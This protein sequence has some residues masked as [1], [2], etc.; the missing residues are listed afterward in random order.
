MKEVADGIP[1]EDTE[2]MTIPEELPLL[3]LR[4]MVLFPDMI[5][6]L[7]VDDERDIALVDAALLRNRMLALI[8]QSD[9][10]ASPPEKE[11][12]HDKGCAAVIL[13]MLKFPDDTT[14]LL[15][16]GISRLAVR[17]FTQEEPFFVGK[18][19][20]LE[21]KKLEEQVAS[22]EK[23]HCNALV[24]TVRERFQHFGSLLPNFP[25]E[26]KVASMNIT[27]PGRLADLIASNIN[28]S[29]AERCSILDSVSVLDR[30][31]RLSVFLE[32]ELQVV[33]LG[34]KIQSDVQDKVGKGQREFFLREQLKAIRAELGEGDDSHQEIEEL[35]QSL[36]E[37]KLPAEAKKESDRELKRLQNMQ[38]GSAEYTVTRTYLDWMA[39]MPWN[40]LT[41]DIL[42]V[43]NARKVMDDD[44]YGLEK[45]KERIIEYLA[46]RKINPEGRG[47][48]LC[49]AG[50][51][52][53]GKTSLGRSI[54]RALGREF[55]RIS[56]GGVRD[57]AEIRGH[58]RTYI[59]ALPGRIIQGLRKVGSRNPVFMMDE[60]DKL[61]ND[62]RGDPASALLEVL[63]PE[64]NHAFS[65]HYLDVPF[66]LSNVMFIMTANNVGT[67]PPALRDRM[68]VLSIPGYSEEEKLK[69]ATRHLVKKLL[70]EHGL[71]RKEIKFTVPGI[72]SIIGNYTRE[73]G[74][75]N[76]EREMAKVCRKVAVR[77]AEK[78]SGVSTIDAHKAHDLL[79]P[80]KFHGE[81]ADR[82]R[83]PGV[84]VGL[85]WTATGGDVLF[86][87]STRM[88][89]KGNLILTG[90]LG[91]VMK[92]SAR[93]A[94]SWIHTHSKAFG[95][96]DREEDI[97]SKS[98]IHLHFPEGAIPKD[99]P[100][101]GI[102]VVVN[103]ISL[104][105]E[106]PVRPK[107]AMTG[108]MTLRGQVLPV[109][110]IKEKMLAARRSGI[111]TVILPKANESDLKELPPEVK[112][113]LSFHPAETIQEALALAFPKMDL[114]ALPAVFAPRRGRKP[115]TKVKKKPA[116]KVVKKAAKKKA[117]TK[118]VAKKAVK[119]VVKKKAK[120]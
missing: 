70:P 80:K 43:R 104:L 46:V 51:P 97:F 115:G 47:P 69:I 105:T 53:V 3:P 39:N 100:S 2:E 103:L 60:V 34:Q 44:H 106:A 49:L 57:E 95:L 94:L 85:A 5:L 50:P 1:T 4:N 65:D 79:G 92:E 111:K 66:D 56:L 52:G 10:E 33:Q 24:R 30:L 58:R 63:D 71:T 40:K 31:G 19:E 78:R 114:S 20:L 98:D 120:R 93:A 110:G 91:D 9:P 17:E 54:A 96:A 45:I 14:R 8:P 55:I 117:T 26:I 16:Q 118:K 86:L 25:E 41:E 68:E 67:I 73:A 109:G 6:P 13:K 64:Q 42:D 88:P 7:V 76:L 102:T 99:G 28:L 75:R 116:K 84:S 29:M 101:A 37:A 38:P 32:R 72:R 113:D 108:E 11:H 77:V 21:E 89:G 119:K 112:R 35:K 15:V 48:I 107:L 36:E 74:L 59:G 90:Q 12:L 61:A 81:A 87:E 22:E 18:I 83:M 27:D 82:T 62:F 23:N